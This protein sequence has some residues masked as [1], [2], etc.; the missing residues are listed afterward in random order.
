MDQTKITK[1][2]RLMKLLTGNVSRT[3]D[4][5]ATEMG[6]TSRT[7]YRYIDTIREAGFVVNKLYGNVYAM[8]KVGRGLSGFNKLIY[9]TEEEA[10]I[11][12]KMINGI[13]NNNV[14]K[15]DLQRKLASIYDSTSIANFIDNT[16]T[17]ANVEALADAIKR[18]KQV[19]LMHYESAHSDEA[20]DRRV[21]PI[22]FTTNMID[23]WAYDV[24]NADNRMF[25]VA[26]IQE[27]EVTDD[28]WAFKSMH[29]VQRPDL[30]RMTGS[31]NEI[32][33]LQLDTRAKSLLLEEFPLAEKELRREN[34]KWILTTRINSLEGVTRFILGLAADIKILEGENLRDYIRK[35]DEQYIHNL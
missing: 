33:S 28:D 24:E 6:I 5:L 13:D 30:F 23:I 25:K 4:Q 29:K 19:V 1:L 2:L 8:G 32:I 17:A 20:K 35:Y 16:A 3:I 7:V 14:L 11:V 21:E 26:R 27:V 31:L 12:A 22:E 34:G 9:F 18:R 15:R 10:Y